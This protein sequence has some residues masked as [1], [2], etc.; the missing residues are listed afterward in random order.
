MWVVFLSTQ[1]EEVF[2]MLAKENEAINN[3]VKK[4]VYVSAEEK[5]RYE[6]EQRQK[7]IKDYYCDIE[8]ARDEGMKIGEQKKQK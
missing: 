1:S 7:A 2:E 8:D 3:A 6:Y 4:L 5:L